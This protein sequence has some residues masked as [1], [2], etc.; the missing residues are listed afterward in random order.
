MSEGSGSFRISLVGIAIAAM[1]LGAGLANQEQKSCSGQPGSRTQD[2]PSIH[3]PAIA[4]AIYA[5][6]DAPPPDPNPARDEWRDE[7]DL[8][9]QRKMAQWAFWMVWVSGAGVLV[10]GIGIIYL[11]M[12]Y[13]EARKATTAAENTVKETRK[14]GEAQIRAYLAGSHGGFRITK[15][16][17]QADLIFRNEGQSPAIGGSA[18]ISLVIWRKL[19][20]GM[21]E[22]VTGEYCGGCLNDRQ[23]IGA[24]AVSSGVSLKSEWYPAEEMKWTQLFAEIS[25]PD[26]K[27][28]IQFIVQFEWRDVFSQ[29]ST[30]CAEFDMSGISDLT[31]AGGNLDARGTL[32]ATNKNY[33]FPE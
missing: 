28:G 12:T 6:A 16:I 13:N 32:Q 20:S 31:P 10:G 27:F 23:T 22:T 15:E 29:S 24:I 18:E 14:I 26:T 33:T 9:A 5:V 1:F 2:Q 4:P 17:V 21:R 30:V 8:Q 25:A 11:A 19:E 3:C 7:K